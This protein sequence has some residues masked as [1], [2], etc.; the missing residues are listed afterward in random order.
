MQYEYQCHMT[1]SLIWLTVQYGQQY[2]I[3]FY[4]T[5][6]HIALVWYSTYCEKSEAI[7][8][9]S[10]KIFVESRILDWGAAE[11]QYFAVMWVIPFSWLDCQ[12]AISC[13]G[14]VY[15]L[16]LPASVWYYICHVGN[17][18]FLAW[19]IG[20]NILHGKGVSDRI[21]PFLFQKINFFI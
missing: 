17:S 4:H 9:I 3:N 15:L 18:I 10:L 1:N 13:R 5:N 16:I 6:G 2:D 12:K 20:G 8:I 11:V 19:L 7:F 21:G 14:R